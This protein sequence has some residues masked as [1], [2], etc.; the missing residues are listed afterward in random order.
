MLDKVQDE[1]YFHTFLKARRETMGITLREIAN[2]VCSASTVLR[3]EQD[4]TVPEKMIR[5]RIV[6]RLGISGEKYEDYL[7]PR[8]YDR[9]MLRQDILK[10]IERKQFVQAEELLRKY[11]KIAPKKSIERQFV[12]AIKFMILQ[13]KNAPLAEQRTLIEEA[14]KE[15]IPM[16]NDNFPK[17]LKELL[18]AD[19]EINLLIEYVA[20]HGTGINEKDIVEWRLNRY[21]EIIEYIENSYI[22]NLGRAKIYPKV[23]YYW[24]KLNNDY[25]KKH[26]LE[27]P[28]EIVE[29][30]VEIC[31]RAVESLRDIRKLFYF[32]ELL[33]LRKLF[34]S[35]KLK[36]VTGEE[37]KELKELIKTTTSWHEVLMGLYQEYEVC[38]Y[39]EHSCH[40]YW[41]MQSYP[42]GEIIKTRRKMMGMT[43][44]ELSDATCDLKSI[45]R[46]EK[47]RVKTQKY[48]IRGVF[49][50]VGLGLENIC[51]NVVTSDA[52][53]LDLY[54]KI[55]RYANIGDLENW[56]K[57]LNELEMKLRM[58]VPENK[59]VIEISHNMLLWCKKMI[60]D[61]ELLSNGTSSL[62][63]TISLESI[64]NQNKRYL[65]KKELYC[66]YRIAKGKEGKEQEKYFLILKEIFEEYENMDNITFYISEYEFIM[67]GISS[68]LGNIQ[69]YEES[70]RVSECVIK[71]CLRHRRMGVLGINC[72]HILWNYYKMREEPII[73]AKDSLE[74]CMRLC[75]IVKNKR[76]VIF[77]THKLAVID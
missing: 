37:A 63:N 64:M 62:E 72:Y 68:W 74:I 26:S 46:C 66:I 54:D 12:A 9:W 33:E 77:L 44:D 76:M 41:E 73:K 21:R 14:V 8:E 43:K 75:E 50:K 27:L 49:P 11:V 16:K 65:T 48:T 36:Y 15:T 17:N 55:T 53:A 18:L 57:Y 2:G 25:Y 58:D 34:C 32:M 40:L 52:E 13:M 29:Y 3:M 6:A 42:M 10:N 24:M 20:L 70:N 69:R 61:E 39:M 1:V 56:E 23:V 59:Q 45:T 71:E 22:D 35:E 51:G 60:S 38:P 67:T 4:E 19:Q 7:P 28:Q 31:D 30:G 5:N 47:D